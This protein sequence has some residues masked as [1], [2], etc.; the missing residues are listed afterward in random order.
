MVDYIPPKFNEKAFN[1]PYCG[2][3]AHQEWFSGVGYGNL[4]RQ[5][6]GDIVDVVG[7]KGKLDGMSVS[8]C[9]HCDN[10]VLWLNE[11]ILLPRNL[12]VPPPPENTPLEVKRIYIEAGMVL[13]DSPRA[14]GALI[15]LALELLLQNINKNKLSLNENIN[16]LME[17]GITQQ[18]IKAVSI[19]RINGNDIMHTGVI[20]IL[21]NKDDVVY[22][23]ELFNMI[24]EEL[25][26]EPKKLNEIYNKIPESKRKQI[27][28]NSKEDRN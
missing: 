18:L 11:N 28:N 23:F 10:K 15:R 9:S 26:E 27:E 8:V 22:L 20:K 2:V 5:Y 7:I 17:S 12:P 21:E 24:V 13:N 14:S 6:M 25:I 1:C 4:A 16:K 19:L 3:Y